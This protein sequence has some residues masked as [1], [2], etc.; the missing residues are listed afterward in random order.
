MRPLSELLSST[1]ASSVPRLTTKPAGATAS[2]LAPA[3]NSTTASAVCVTPLT[4]QKV[5]RVL[6]SLPRHWSHPGRAH[7]RRTGSRSRLWSCPE[8]AG[9]SRPPGPPPP[10][11]NLLAA[12]CSLSPR[13]SHRVRSAL[14]RRTSRPAEQHEGGACDPSSRAARGAGSPQAHMVADRDDTGNEVPRGEGGQPW[15]AL[16]VAHCPTRGRDPACHLVQDDEGPEN[17]LQLEGVVSAP[18]PRA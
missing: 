7:S 15:W 13:P 3:P 17:S 11:A 5:P 10:P 16:F 9:S 1:R 6:R 12:E 18:H 2:S 8:E 14:V 4:R